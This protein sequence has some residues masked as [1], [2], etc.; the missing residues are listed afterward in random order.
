MNIYLVAAL[1]SFLTRSPTIHHIKQVS[2]SLWRAIPILSRLFSLRRIQQLVSQPLV[3]LPIVLHGNQGHHPLSLRIKR[4][5]RVGLPSFDLRGGR[6]GTWVAVQI[7]TAV[8][9]SS[10]T[11]GC[12][13]RLG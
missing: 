12:S 9:V 11:G 5:F 6:G 7:R 13:R 8:P 4:G 10:V 2:P 1:L 3:L